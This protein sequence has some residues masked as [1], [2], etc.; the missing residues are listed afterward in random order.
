MSLNQGQQA[1]VSAIVHSV[2]KTGDLGQCLVGE[3]G[4]GKTYCTMDI[5]SQLLDAGMKIIL[6]APTNKAVKQMEKAERA[7]GLNMERLVFKTLHSALGLGLM[8]SEDKK[9][10]HRVRDSILAEFDVVGIDEASMLSA[11]A[12]NEYLLEEQAKASN[13]FF[14]LMIGDDMQLPPVKEKESLAFK[15]YP[16]Q[17][18]TQNERVL[19]NPD[20][21][22]N[23]IKELIAPLREAIEQR[24]L[25]TL[26]KIPDRNVEVLKA[27]DF[28]KQVIGYF[29]RD[30]NL[31]DVRVLAWTNQRVNE[32]N[33]AIRAKVYGKGA[34]RF[35][36]GEQLVTG[37][38]VING[39]GEVALST[40]EECL[41]VSVTE[42]D[43]FDEESGDVYRTWQIVLNPIYAEVNQVIVH[44]LHEDE[45]ERYQARLDYLKSKAKLAA[46][47]AAGNWWRKWHALQEIFA[48]MRYCY[49]IT[50]HRSQGATLQHSIV[51]VKD[52]LRNDLSAERKRL[53]YVAFSRAREQ[54]TIN[55]SGFTA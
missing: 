54:L 30:T 12:I 32:I 38:P 47:S 4:T 3:G 37:S 48:D 51:D 9:Y 5:V 22:P 25:F 44:V 28:L 45:Q 39:D 50:V 21:T 23:G 52:I 15:L 7:A 31:E 16:N 10:P 34:A 26:R 19:V 40:D 8:P 53:L 43:Q 41:V 2:L 35:E 18:L 17:V 11:R 24:K 20:G 33:A 14:I 36:V 49:C 29:D 55:K 13:P 46:G 42:G 27:A 6:T 1:A